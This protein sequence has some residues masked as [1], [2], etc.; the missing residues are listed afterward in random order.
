[1]DAFKKQLFI[2]LG[3]GIGVIVLAVIAMQATSG[4]LAKTADEIEKRKDELALRT[5][6]TASL[7]ELRANFAKAQPY[8]RILDSVFPPKD[9]LINF[10]RDFINLGKQSGLELG[11]NFG[12]ENPSS[13]DKPGFISF[14]AS[15][16]G[17]QDGFLRFLK[18][19]EKS[20]LFIKINSLDLVRQVSADTFNIV[21]DGQVFFQ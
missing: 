6:V 16:K 10:G 1:M 4:L 18:D 7:A 21:L 8:Q 5:A 12:N 15:G 11:F 13:T 14:S 19:L 2:S 3:T 9:D 17:T 20:T